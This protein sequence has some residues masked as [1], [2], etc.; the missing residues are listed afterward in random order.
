[1]PNVSIHSLYRYFAYHFRTRR[2]RY[3][4]REFQLTLD[5]LVLDVGGAPFNWNL[6]SPVPALT[7]LNLTAYRSAE[8]TKWVIGDGCRLP[9]KSGSFDIVYSN[10]VIEHLGTWEN[11]QAFAAECQRV[12]RSYYIQTPNKHFFMEPHLLTPFIHWLPRAWQRKLLRYF[13]LWGWLTKPSSAQCSA[14]MDEIRLLGRR[15]LQTLF[16]DAEIWRERFLGMTKSYIVVKRIKDT[17]DQDS[18]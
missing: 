8:I 18:E 13:T 14:F 2:M 7:M 1:M 17:I 5:T 16:P 9:F 4:A 6:L 12:G 11:Q 10:S 3:F 15:E